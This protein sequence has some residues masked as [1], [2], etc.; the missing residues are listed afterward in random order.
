VGLLEFYVIESVAMGIASAQ[1]DTILCGKKTACQAKIQGTQDRL[2][3]CKVHF[4]R[5]C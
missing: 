1:A 4:K 3:P 5:C 2:A